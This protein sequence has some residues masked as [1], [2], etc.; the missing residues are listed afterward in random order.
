MSH[1]HW[2]GGTFHLSDKGYGLNQLRYDLRK[3]RGHGL[4]EELSAES[5]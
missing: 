5:W 3:L 2:H 4:I 1:D